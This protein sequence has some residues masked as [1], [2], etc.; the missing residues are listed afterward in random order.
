MK[1]FPS[2]E[3]GGRE[4]RVQVQLCPSSMASLLGWRP[5]SR[6]PCCPGS[7][8]KSGPHVPSDLS[9]ACVPAL[10]ARLRAPR[11]GPEA[12]RPTAAGDPE[13]TVYSLQPSSSSLSLLGGGPHLL[14]CHNLGWLSSRRAFW[15][16][17]LTSKI[18]RAVEL[19]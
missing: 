11:T 2:R 16:S 3:D 9:C 15:L 7:S 10:L 4:G 5:V 6:G 19:H 13:L 12:G 14:L 8:H 18:S 1:S 17:F